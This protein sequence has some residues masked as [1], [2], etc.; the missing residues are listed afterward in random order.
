[1]LS[2]TTFNK[3]RKKVAQTAHGKSSKRTKL[4]YY[5]TVES[6][7]EMQASDDDVEV[8]STRAYKLPKPAAPHLDLK[9]DL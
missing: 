8:I 5:P 9:L 6:D 4:R 1:M 3:W 7:E 2:S